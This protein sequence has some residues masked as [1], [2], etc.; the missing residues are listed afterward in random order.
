MCEQIINKTFP[1]LA[2]GYVQDDSIYPIGVSLCIATI[3]YSSNN[4]GVM[5]LVFKNPDNT[6]EQVYEIGTNAQDIW[7]GEE[8]LYSSS[9]TDAKIHATILKLN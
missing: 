8:G 6:I 5:A 2:E 3:N 4:Q 9:G 1:G 7:W